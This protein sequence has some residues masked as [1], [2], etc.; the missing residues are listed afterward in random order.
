M[1]AIWGFI[2][3]S[4]YYLTIVSA[5]MYRGIMQEHVH[6]EG[7]FELTPQF[8]KDV[9]GLRLLSPQFIIRWLV[10][11]PLLYFVWWSSVKALQQPA[12][13]SFLM[14]ALILREIAVHLRHFRNL[15]LYNFGKSGGVKGR[16]EYSRW[17][18]LKLSAAELLSFSVIYGFLALMERSW[19]FLGGVLGCLVVAFQHWR[20]SKKASPPNG[21]QIQKQTPAEQ[22]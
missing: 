22:R 18:I 7:S 15:A 4:D 14:G 21:T 16:I 6:Y 13:F 10:S 3:L 1:L 8:Q 9:D 2:Y 5:K 20:L 17:L 12:F 19:F 11:F